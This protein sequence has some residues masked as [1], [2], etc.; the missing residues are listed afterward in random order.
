MF[1]FKFLYKSE[2]TADKRQ[3]HGFFILSYEIKVND[4]KKHPEN[5][6]EDFKNLLKC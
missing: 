2:E 6:E 4:V 3:S 5:L 1:L